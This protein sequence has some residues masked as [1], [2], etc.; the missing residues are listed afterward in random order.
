MSDD[1]HR[2]KTP[3]AAA[4]IDARI[5]SLGRGLGLDPPALRSALSA[6][7]QFPFL[8]PSSYLRKIEAATQPEALIR[9][10]L[11]LGVELEDA[12]GFSND[13]LDEANDAV[14]GLIEK[15]RGRL[16]VMVTRACA[17]HCRFCFRR[18]LPS[19]PLGQAVV[20]DAFRARMAREGD[21][22]EV[23]LSGGDPLVLSDARLTDWFELIAAYPQVRRIRIH[24]RGPVFSPERVNDGLLS[25]LGR[26]RLPVVL[27]VH[28]NH[29]DELDAE[30]ALALDRLRRAGVM[31]ISQSVLL[32]GVNDSVE[33]LE[34]LFE[35]LLE[36]GVLP[37]YLHQLDRI[38]GA[39]HFEVGRAR[40]LALVQELRQRLPGYMVPRYVEEIPGEPSKRP[41]A[42]KDAEFKEDQHADQRLSASPSR[43]SP[44]TAG[45]DGTAGQPPGRTR[46]VHKA[47]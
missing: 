43:S 32:T 33:S 37:Y 30:T 45:A 36:C 26:S 22:S 6:A 40:G 44:H 2:K 16:L 42:D 17:G 8:A 12:D 11:P 3:A 19:A 29:A 35:R 28:V 46:T 21:I 14:D 25:V 9:Q 4:G 41:I 47:G 20:R 5:A 38:A 27:A 13:P 34:R 15:Y 7:D 31:L 39:A 1:G 24:T 23:I 18:H 10:V